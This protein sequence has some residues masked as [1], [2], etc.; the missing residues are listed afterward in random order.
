MSAPG[1]DCAPFNCS[2]ST[3]S[4]PAT[5]ATT[6]DCLPDY[7]CSEGK[8]VSDVTSVAAGY[9][10][11]CAIQKSGKTV[12][13]GDNGSGQLGIGTVGGRSLIPAEVQ[14]LP[15]VASLSLGN[16]HSCALTKDGRV[17]CWGSNELGQLG[18]GGTA[19]RGAAAPVKLSGSGGDLS[20]A[21]ALSAGAIHT[22]VLASGGVHCWGANNESQLARPKSMASSRVPV[23]VPDSA[24]ARILVTGEQSSGFLDGS[25]FCGWGWNIVKQ[26]DDTAATNVLTPACTSV[27]D[28]AHAVLGSGHGCGRLANNAVQC[29][30]LVLGSDLVVGP[31]PPGAPVPG[32]SFSQIVSGGGHVC[33]HSIDGRIRCWGS[34]SWG[35]HGDGTTEPR[36]APTNPV[37]TP[38][39]ATLTEV[40]PGGLGSGGGS[41]HTCAIIN[42]GSVR[43]WGWNY[44]GQIGLGYAGGLS[45]RAALVKWQ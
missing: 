2:T 4:C 44:A 18:D 19:D 1:Q 34:G 20:G 7:F 12:C 9:W 39:G 41:G 38:D 5:C 13:W 25:R 16:G 14:G 6:A 36:T 31:G 35:T 22:C 29:W 27:S 10:H 43:C 26:V 23:L 45:E 24:T 15:A 32:A 11:S 33:G 3:T 8:C 28:L 21:S 30:G 37:V 17:F 40:I 42:D